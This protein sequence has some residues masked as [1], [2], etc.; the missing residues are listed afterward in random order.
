VSVRAR[1]LIPVVAVVLVAVGV[2][3]ALLAD[4]G[5][6]EAEEEPVRIGV[7]NDQETL[8]LGHVLRELL[9][10]EEVA[11]EVVSFGH[12]SDARRAVEFR[13][14]DLVPTY[15]GAVWLDEFGWADPS[16]DPSTS[17][18]RVRSEDARRGLVWLPPTEA[19]AT[20][21]FVVAGPPAET[22]GF[23]SLTDLV[24]AVNTDPEAM[25]CVDPDYAE[26][27]DG[28]A[29]LARLYSIHEE[30]LANQLLAAPPEEAVIGVTRGGCI[31]GMTTTT[32]GR[33]WVAGLRTL[34]DPQRTFP[35]FVVAAV[36]AEAAL[37]EQEG[38][39]EALAPFGPA[40]TTQPRA[41]G[42]R[43]LVLGEPVAE[44]AADAAATLVEAHAALLEEEAEEDE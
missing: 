4:R 31:A 44:V 43:R 11:A 15:T 18:E 41:A 14:V 28:F 27:P 42:N 16:G 10:A 8:L 1:T 20:F 25:L 39:E 19:N 9:A 2:V 6:V 33:A 29:E 40:L 36:A 3:V 37:A 38:L 23:D 32:D 13:E 30:V 21:T 12:A 7:A 26:R 24:V 17:Y 5:G 35:A 22:A 34:S